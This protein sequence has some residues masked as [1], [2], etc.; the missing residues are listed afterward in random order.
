M[1]LSDLYP[2]TMF[3]SIRTFALTSALLGFGL[4]P[5][6]AQETTEK[7]VGTFSNPSADIGIVVKDLEKSAKFYTETLGMTEVPGLLLVI[8]FCC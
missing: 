3:P 6:L 1:P 2:V 4:F 5:A 8:C 7:P